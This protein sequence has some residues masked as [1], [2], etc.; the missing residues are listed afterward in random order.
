MAATAQTAADMG[1]PKADKPKE[2]VISSRTFPEVRDAIDGYARKEHR[3][4]A[5]MIDLLLREAIIARRKKDKE[6]AADIERLP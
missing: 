4:I 5:Q 2:S 1:R 3:T 6:S